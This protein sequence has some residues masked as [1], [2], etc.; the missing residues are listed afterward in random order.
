MRF[1]EYVMIFVLLFVNLLHDQISVKMYSNLNILLLQRQVLY[2]VENNSTV[3]Q[4]RILSQTTTRWKKV[5]ETSIRK[6]RRMSLHHNSIDSTKIDIKQIEIIKSNTTIIYVL[7]NIF[8]DKWNMSVL[9]LRFDENFF[10]R[11]T[12]VHHVAIDDENDEFEND[13]DDQNDDDDDDDDQNDN[14]DD[15]DDE[16]LNAFRKNV[17]ANFEE[18]RNDVD[19]ESFEKKKTESMNDQ[20]ND[21]VESKKNEEDDEM[22]SSQN[23]VDENR[24]LSSSSSN[25]SSFSEFSSSKEKEIA[26]FVTFQRCVVFESIFDSKSSSDFR[27]NSRRSSQT[28]FKKKK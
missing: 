13:D 17:D 12:R 7:M 6:T 8:R 14:D 26:S 16:E 5:V 27:R 20:K 4:R 2:A 18:Y 21:V 25:E 3:A 23:D 19:V 24:A 10:M 1:C 9:I 11:S 28:S 15:D 22:T